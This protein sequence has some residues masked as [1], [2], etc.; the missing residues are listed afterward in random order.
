MSDYSAF[1]AWEDDDFDLESELLDALYTTGDYKPIEDRMLAIW[2]FMFGPEGGIAEKGSAF[3]LIFGACAYAG[4]CAG[5]EAASNGLEMP[6][7][8]V[9]S[10]A[11][12]WLEKQNKL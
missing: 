2:N 10:V 7:D 8:D 9:A 11:W 5:I 12:K 1:K 4:W 6:G 3:H